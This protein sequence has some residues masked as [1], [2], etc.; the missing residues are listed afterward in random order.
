MWSRIS[1]VCTVTKIVWT[2]RGSKSVKDNILFLS[3]NFRLVFG[4]HPTSYSVGTGVRSGGG[5]RLDVKLNTHVRMVPEFKSECCYIPT[6]PKYFVMAWMETTSAYV[7]FLNVRMLFN[8]IWM[9]GLL[10]HGFSQIR[11]FWPSVFL[12]PI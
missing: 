7:L 11:R 2:I 9:K 10:Q 3:P 5:S 1:V 8:L 12:L 4:A 6:P